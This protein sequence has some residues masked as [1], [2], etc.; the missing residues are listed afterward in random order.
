MNDP[1]YP[2]WPKEPG[3]PVEGVG[4]NLVLG[5]ETLDEIMR[6]ARKRDEHPM[7]TMAWMIESWVWLAQNG[8]LEAVVEQVEKDIAKAKQDERTN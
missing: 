6:Y 2:G 8:Y 3:T 4:A 5:Q 7:V 1:I